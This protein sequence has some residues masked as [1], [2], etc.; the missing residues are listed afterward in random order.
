MPPL[1]NRRSASRG[2]TLLELMTV[3]LVVLI[4]G[5]MLLPVYSGIE[6]RA[7][8]SGCIAN[9]RSLHVATD[10][11][12]QEH[13]TWPQIKTD[14]VDPKIVAANW[15]STLQPYGLSQINWLCPTVQKTLEN[16]DMTDPENTRLDYAASPFDTN[17]QTPFRWAKQPWFVE[18]ADAHGNGQL[19][20]FPDGHVEELMDF[21]TQLKKPAA[22]AGQ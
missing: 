14:G 15:I 13:H 18:M 2:F 12:L 1:L 5:V 17:P 4:L 20:L 7:Q 16:P 9:L 10:L 11:Y 8:K 22:S 3:I 19:I 6:R 21:L